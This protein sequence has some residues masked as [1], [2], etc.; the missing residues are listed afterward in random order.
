M[1]KEDDELKEGAT[2]AKLF[3][4]NCGE[5]NPLLVELKELGKPVLVSKLLAA[6]VS[7]SV[8]LALPSTLRLAPSLSSLFRPGRP[9]PLR[10]GT[11]PSP[12][13]Q[14]IFFVVAATVG[15]RRR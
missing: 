1:D 5:K 2:E 11:G 10:C 6:P 14:I 7:A 13:Q 12:R 15:A 4:F 8:W 3:C 9:G